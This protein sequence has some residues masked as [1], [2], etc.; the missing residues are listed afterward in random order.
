VPVVKYYRTA[1]GS[2]YILAPK[3]NS[4]FCGAHETLRFHLAAR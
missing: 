3:Q 1:M 2:A 4:E